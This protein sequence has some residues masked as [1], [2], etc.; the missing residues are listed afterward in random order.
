M[1]RNYA[2]NTMQIKRAVELYADGYSRREIAAYF[3]CCDAA[4]GNALRLAGVKLRDQGEATAMAN[5]R[6]AARSRGRPASVWQYA[7]QASA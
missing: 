4:A 3:G 5:K 2:L 7:Q 6:R 1:G